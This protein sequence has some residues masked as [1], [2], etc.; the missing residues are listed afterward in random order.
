GI[1][2]W[3][4]MFGDNSVPVWSPKDADLSDCT[5]HWV[6]MLEDTVKKEDQLVTNL[7][8]RLSRM[9]KIKTLYGGDM[10]RVMDIVVHLVSRMEAVLDEFGDYRSRNQFVKDVLD[11]I[12]ESCNNLFDDFH[13]NSWLD[14]PA[15]QRSE[16]ATHLIGS[17][18]RTSVLLSESRTANSDYNRILSNIYVG[19]HTRISKETNEGIEFP[20]MSATSS[21]DGNALHTNN[22]SNDLLSSNRVFLPLQTLMKAEKE[23]VI[24][25]TM[26]VYSKLDAL[27]APNKDNVDSNIMENETVTILNSNIVGV[28]LNKEGLPTQSKVRITF[29]HLLTTNVTDPKCVFWNVG[30]FK[31]S[32]SGCEVINWNRS[33]TTCECNHLTNFAVLMQMRDIPLSTAHETAFRLITVVGCSIS[34]FCLLLTLIIFALCK[35]VK[36]DRIAIHTNLCVCLLLGELV[37]LFGISQTEPVLLCRVIALVLH[38]IF[39]SAFLWMFFEGFQLYVMLIEVFESERSRLRYYYLFA[40]GIPLIIVSICLYLDPYSYG[41]SRHCWLRNDNY[42]ILSF[43]GPVVAIIMSNLVFLTIAL[44]VMWRHISS[45]SSVAKPNKDEN[46]IKSIRMWLRGALALVFILGITWIFGLLYLNQETLIMAYLF[47]IFNSFQGLFIFIFHCL[48]NE[49][50]RREYSKLMNSLQSKTSCFSSSVDNSCSSKS[51]DKRKS[52]NHSDATSVSNPNNFSQTQEPIIAPNS[53]SALTPTLRRVTTPSGAKYFIT[54][55]VENS[56]PEHE[57]GFRKVAEELRNRQ[58]QRC[59]G[60]CDNAQNQ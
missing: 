46:R 59:R 52:P 45:V 23:S 34:A 47:T 26:I 18:E 44:C 15:K 10:H 53:G 2:R 50:V 37:F 5:S 54:G 8:G 49:K 3:S 22:K 38:Y 58:K 41:T 25:I 12:Q 21:A 7:A 13:R 20:L 11:S 35:N 28:V 19:V 24:R 27:F 57:Y 29:K 1:A 31:W 42:F 48:Q 16:V 60:H 4:C 30:Q 43:V 39:L 40:Y 36:G 33:H 51:P 14:L 9:T 17:L 32:S 6:L 56:I 55:K